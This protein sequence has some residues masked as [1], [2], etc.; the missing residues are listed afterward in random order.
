MRATL[1]PGL[2]RVQG[3]VAQL[4]QVVMNLIAN[5][6]EALGRNSGTITITTSRI[7]RTRSSE[8]A[9]S[10]A[11]LGE[12]IRLTVSDTGCGM[13][14][15]TRAKIF[16]QFFTTKSTGRGL[17]LAA[18]RGIV[19]S[20]GGLIDVTS[21]P[22]AGATFEVLLPCVKAPVRLDNQGRTREPQPIT[23]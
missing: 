8:E 6:S 10:T 3:N 17:G 1:D 11:G 22:G 18:V 21:S 5:A 13:S 9:E 12:Y 23:S 4:R 16:D 20:H 14:V 15:E 7:V 2:P 19:R